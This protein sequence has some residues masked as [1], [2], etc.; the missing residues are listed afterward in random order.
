MSHSRGAVAAE[1]VRIAGADEDEGG[2]GKWRLL[3]LRDQQ[4]LS[5]LPGEPADTHQ[6]PVVAEVVLSAQPV[7]LRFAHRVEVSRVDGNPEGLGG[8]HDP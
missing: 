2:L 3:P 5:L 6:D 8:Q 1:C 7:P 4:V